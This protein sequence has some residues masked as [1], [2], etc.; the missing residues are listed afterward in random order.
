MTI[1]DVFVDGDRIVWRWTMS[2]THLG[3]FAGALPTNRKVSFSG[4]NVE[5]LEGDQIAEHWSFHDS[6][7]LLAELGV[8]EYIVP[9][10][11]Y[12]VVANRTVGGAKLAE[13]L[14]SLMKQEPG[15]EFVVLVPAVPTVLPWSAAAA[16]PEVGTLPLDFGHV[17][18]EVKLYAEQQL[19]RLVDWLRGE[20][21]NAVGEIGPAEPLVA[22]DWALQRRRCDE[23]I[24][25]S[26]PI[27]T[28]ALARHRR[29]TACPPALRYPRHHGGERRPG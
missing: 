26:L 3:P 11:R 24:I 25:S 7:S 13:H 12:L 18:R 27:G 6:Y 5:R 16:M 1:D 22:I 8:L 19:R 4:M 14:R 17:E 10:K 15:S 28:S 29:L 20:G 2:G 9:A 23:I 21:A